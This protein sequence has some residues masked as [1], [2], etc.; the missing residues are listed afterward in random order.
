MRRASVIAAFML[1]ATSALAA[2]DVAVDVQNASEP[3]LCAEKDNVYL[4]L[5]SSEVRQ[6]KIESVHPNYIG[7][8]VVDRSAFDLHNCPDLAAAPYITE[9]PRRI[10][11]FENQE[12]QLIGHT[13]P[14]FWR[15]TIVPV[16]VGDRVETGAQLLQL[17]TRTQDRA[18]EVLVL[19]PQDG[20]WRARPLPPVNL[21]WSAYGSSFLVGPV[22]MDQRPFVNIREVVF[23]PN[24]RSF[25]LQFARGGSATLRLETLDTDKQ[26][27]DVTLDQPV[28]GDVPFAA[29]RSMFVTEINNDVAHLGWRVKGAQSWERTPIMDF[30]RAS[31]VEVWAGRL[32]PSRHNTSAP[33]T[34]FRDFKRR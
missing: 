12:W 29:L 7:T 26:V 17:W 11:I 31:A 20:Y 5:A 8:I 24:T 14:N 1:L 28:G 32:V 10:T 30:R 9:K 16:R 3:T 27:L 2:D 6:F 18:E 15:K 19:Y 33:D 25:R 34:I 21:K 23:D 13:I 22:E 4:K